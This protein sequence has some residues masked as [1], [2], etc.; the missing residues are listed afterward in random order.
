LKG[1]HSIRVRDWRYT[2]YADGSEEL[3]DHRSDPNEWKNIA[4][5]PGSKAM[6]ANLQ[7]WLP[8]TNAEPAEGINPYGKGRKIRKQAH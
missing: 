8:K 3:Y 4:A 1:N 2:Q 7:K 5:S 6:I